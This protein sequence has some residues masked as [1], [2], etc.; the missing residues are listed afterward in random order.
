MFE[1]KIAELNGKKRK[2]S[3]T[4]AEVQEI[5]GISRPSVYALIGQNLFR[6]VMLDNQYR[7]V[8][9]SFDSWLDG[10]N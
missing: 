10:E 7:I 9:S 1:D 5:L 3:Y 4:V 8:K 6:T 2:N